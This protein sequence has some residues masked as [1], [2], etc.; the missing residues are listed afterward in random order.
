L[1]GIILSRVFRLVCHAIK[2]KEIFPCVQ[3]GVI[4]AVFEPR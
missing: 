1:G 3:H 2:L 4:T